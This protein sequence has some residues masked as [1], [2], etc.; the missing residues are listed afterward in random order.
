MLS[1]L[2]AVRGINFFINTNNPNFI[3]FTSPMEATT[4]SILFLQNIVQNGNDMP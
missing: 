1:R 4:A 2:Q 3:S